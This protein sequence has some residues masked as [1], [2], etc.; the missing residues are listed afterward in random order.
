MKH[1]GSDNG[2]SYLIVDHVEFS[3]SEIFAKFNKQFSNDTVY[4]ICME[5]MDKLGQ[6]ASIGRTMLFDIND[7]FVIMEEENFDLVFIDAS[8]V[9]ALNEGALIRAVD[10]VLRMLELFRGE[11]ISKD[12][13]ALR[14]RLAGFA[15]DVFSV[16]KHLQEF[17]MRILKPDPYMYEQR[18]YDWF[19]MPFENLSS[20]KVKSK[21]FKP[22]EEKDFCVDALLAENDQI[23]ADYIKEIQLISKSI[24]LHTV[25]D[26]NDLGGKEDNRRQ[27]SGCSIF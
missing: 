18:M 20:L 21:P 3:L 26:P 15:H 6:L 2:V 14:E 23:T 17:L 13:L 11:E 10:C 16:K 1:S 22:I 5:L 7:V 9:I 25:E 12:V 24:K 27:S 4:I 19:V 8:K